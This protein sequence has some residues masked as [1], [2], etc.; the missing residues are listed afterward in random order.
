MVKN[1][2][3][4][5]CCIQETHTKNLL[6]LSVGG[7]KLYMLKIILG[8]GK[9]PRFRLEFSVKIW[10]TIKAYQAKFKANQI[11]CRSSDKKT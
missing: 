2:L 6:N 1:S 4:A 11:F 10:K 9:C 7:K 5:M 3:S 8:K